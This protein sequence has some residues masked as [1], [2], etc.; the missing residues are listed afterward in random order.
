MKAEAKL[1]ADTFHTQEIWHKD[2]YIYARDPKYIRQTTKNKVFCLP[3]VGLEPVT[4][5]A[6]PP[7]L[8][9]GQQKVFLCF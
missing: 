4:F 7:L 6:S 8:K 5:W 9:T 3:L 2:N 1:S